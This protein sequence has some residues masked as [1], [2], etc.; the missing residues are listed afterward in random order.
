MNVVSGVLCIKVTCEFSD[1]SNGEFT[2]KIS[3]VKDVNPKLESNSHNNGVEL[4]K[5]K[6]THRKHRFDVK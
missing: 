2:K 1:Y 3:Q 4:G 6:K 5:K